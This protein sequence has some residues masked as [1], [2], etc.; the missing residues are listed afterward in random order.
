MRTK[1]ELT[2]QEPPRILTDAEKVQ[3]CLDTLVHPLK[4]EIEEVRKIIKTNKHLSERMKWN[5]PS[6]YYKEDLLTFDLHNQRFVHLVFHNPEVMNVN[7]KLLEGH[8][9]N[10][11]MVYFDNMKSVNENKKELAKIISDLIKLVNKKLSY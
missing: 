8:Y 7:S 3:N 11:R 4:A 6:Y 10:K 9:S 1:K 2:K 5:A